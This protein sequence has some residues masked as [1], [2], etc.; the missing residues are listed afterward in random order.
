MSPRLLLDTHILLRWLYGSKRLSREQLR[1][2]EAAARRGEPLGVGAVTLLEISILVEDQKLEIDGALDVLLD[3]LNRTPFQLL[4]LTP[5]IAFEAG[6]MAS[7]RDPMDRAI[8]ATARVHGLRLVTS[9]QR[10]IESNVVSTI[11]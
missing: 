10:I 5:A 2:I 11:E 3:S 8:A 7:L 1:V 4:P 9:D 6:A